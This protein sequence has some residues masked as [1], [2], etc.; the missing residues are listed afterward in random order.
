[1]RGTH[2]GAPFMGIE[3]KGRRFEV[4]TIDIVRMK[5]G[6]A[7]EMWGVRDT[8]DLL[9]QLGAEPDFKVHAE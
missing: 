5:D 9:R 1:M 3:A 7:I 6:L 8:W 2:T 4:Q